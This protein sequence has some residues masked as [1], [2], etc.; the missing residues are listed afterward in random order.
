VRPPARSDDA[1]RHPLLPCRTRLLDLEG[2]DTEGHQIRRQRPRLPEPHVFHPLAGRRLAHR[3]GV[4]HR[5]ELDGD[6]Q[7]QL[8]GNLRRRLVDTGEGAP[9]VGLLELGE[10]VP[11]AAALLVEDARVLLGELGAAELEP[12][13]HRT[14]GQRMREAQRHPLVGSHHRL[15]RYG[16]GAHPRGRRADLQRV[17]V[18]PDHLDRR[19]QRPFDLRPPREAVR[20]GDDRQPHPLRRGAEGSGEAD[21]L[22]RDERGGSRQGD[23]GGLR[24]ARRPG[25][26]GTVGSTGREH[27]ERDEEG[28]A[29][30]HEGRALS[31]GS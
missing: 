12:E 1:H 19:V 16:L 18:Q 22:R 4:G 20:R 30:G 13:S 9:C 10:G 15:G 29:D 7:G 31:H 27:E 6:P 2:P 14:W 3:R 5:G 25:R 17:G 11:V 26:S 8:P 23:G 21:A 24:G 28:E